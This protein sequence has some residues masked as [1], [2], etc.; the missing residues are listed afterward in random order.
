MT[1]WNEEKE[2]E[3][4]PRMLTPL[5]MPQ[6]APPVDRARSSSARTDD[7][8]GVEANFNVGDLLKNILF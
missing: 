8:S 2:R 3:K 6:Q 1:R 7:A 4:S 5:A